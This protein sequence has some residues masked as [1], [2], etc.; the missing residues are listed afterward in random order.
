MRLLGLGVRV[1]R[2]WEGL[3]P[4]NARWKW[5]S[6]RWMM[7]ALRAGRGGGGVRDAADMCVWRNWLIEPEAET[8]LDRDREPDPDVGM[9]AERGERGGGAAPAAPASGGCG[10]RGGRRVRAFA[11]LSVGARSDGLRTS[12]QVELVAPA[13][14]AR[15]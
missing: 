12:L 2:S 15:P 1:L 10:A 4:K 8:A 3:D 9:R 13:P 14:I 6:R 7:R 5:N 11:M